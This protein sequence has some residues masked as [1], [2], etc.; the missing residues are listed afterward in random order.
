MVVGDV[1]LDCYY[2]GSV[3]RISPEAPVPV[4]NLD[5]VTYVLGGAG[6]VA[7]NV[8]GF[9][10]DAI[11]LGVKGKDKEGEILTSL[12]RDHG[13]TDYLAVEKDRPTTTKTRVVA[14]NQHLLRIDSEVTQPLYIRSGNT[15]RSRM[16]T[17]LSTC[18][19]IVISDYAKGAVSEQM[20]ADVVGLGK[21]HK[22]PVFVDPKGTSWVRYGDAFCITP[23]RKEFVEFYHVN[24]GGK[25][26]SIEEIV[27][28]APNIVY[29]FNLTYMCVTLGADGILLANE[30]E[31]H[32]LPVDDRVEVADVSGAGDTVI[33]AF[34]S[35][36]AG[37]ED[38]CTIDMRDMK[39]IVGY[40]NAAA[41][42]AVSR[43]GTIPVSLYE[44][45]YD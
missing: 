38:P 1:M 9:R 13:I 43:L 16:K 15:L 5:E 18:N 35:S 11:L 32:V 23:N 22:I 41:G 44:V 2:W 40:A 39:H 8:V 36:A 42:I 31:V 10:H 12:L 33:A 30:D 45:D 27:A 7:A 21:K 14:G 20:A 37:I 19:A 4:V 28:V 26:D 34:A 24:Y 6:N 25:L 29:E 3:N 17:V